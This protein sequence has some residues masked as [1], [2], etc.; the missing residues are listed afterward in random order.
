MRDHL[1]AAAKHTDIAVAAI[2]GGMA[3]EKQIRLLNRGP[4]IVV[5]TPGRLWDLVQDGHHHL[6]QLDKIRSVKGFKLLIL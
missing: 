3:A 1:L 2:V 4:A 6:R 5:A